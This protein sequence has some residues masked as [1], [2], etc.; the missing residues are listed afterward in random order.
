MIE[1]IVFD[2][3]NTLAHSGGD[4]PPMRELAE[5]LGIADQPG[6][7]R[8]IER[9]MMLAPAT[10][11]EGALRQLQARE[12]LQ[13]TDPFTRRR[14]AECWSSHR[15]SLFSD[16]LPALESLSRRF[17]LGLCSNTQSFGLEFLDRDGVWELLDASALSFEIGAL[18][19][20]PV[21]FDTICRRMGLAADKL[22]MVGDR[23]GDD[24]QGA[25]RAGLQALLLDR[26]GTSNGGGA[27]NALR[28]LAELPE[29]I[30][31]L[32]GRG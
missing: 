31:R 21:I 23:L 12:G 28:S 13:L 24:V 26:D 14:L 16:A 6:W 30:D 25:R 3:W 20:E 32:N 11:M 9:G 17:R 18:K 4:T 10:G 15:T 5:A 7:A 27:E 29:R 2:L 22:L 19:P 1:G 8:R